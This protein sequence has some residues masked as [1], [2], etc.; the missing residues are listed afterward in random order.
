MIITS[1]T[2]L[3]TLGKKEMLIDAFED[4]TPI[5]RKIDKFGFEYVE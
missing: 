3:D 4:I 2:I 5:E 1:N